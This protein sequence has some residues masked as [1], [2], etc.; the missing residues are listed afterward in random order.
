LRLLVPAYFYPAGDGLAQWDR[1]LDSPAAAVTVAVA[2][3]DS[4]PGAAADP[5][6]AQVLERA[7][8]KGVTV[9]GYVSTKYAARPLHEV[10]ADVD[11]WARFYPEVRGI[12][13]DE[14]PSTADQVPYYASLYRHAREERGLGLV[15]TNPGAACAEDEDCASGFCSHELAVCASALRAD[16][17]SIARSLAD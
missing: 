15:V 2:N 5:N 13:F 16:C 4:G 11:R 10:M 7:R 3:P 17:E 6:Y 14:Q 1:L 9:L 12:F 8:H